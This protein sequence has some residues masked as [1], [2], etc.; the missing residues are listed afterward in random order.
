MRGQHRMWCHHPNL[1]LL[2]VPVVVNPV[3]FA[4]QDHRA[5]IHKGNVEALG[6]LNLT[7]KCR[8]YLKNDA[9]DST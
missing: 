5:V 4:G 7:L 8:Q 1:W 6:V 3:V 2:N 9:Q